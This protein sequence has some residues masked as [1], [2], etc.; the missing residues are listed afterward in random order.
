MAA[1]KWIAG[2]TA[3]T[4]LPEAA[5]LV[6]GARLQVVRDYLSLALRTPEKDTEYIHQL[7]V[8]A[9]RANAAVRIF[10]KCLPK[11]VYKFL[12]RRLRDV[13]R[14]A[15]AARDWDVFLAGLSQRLQDAPHHHRGLDYLV[16][17]ALAQRLLAQDTLNQAVAGD[18]AALDDAMAA[19]L[20][21]VRKPRHNGKIL[22]DQARSA[23]LHLLDTLAEAAAGD[24]SD[25]VQLHQVRIQAKRLRYGMEIFASC[26]AEEFQTV[27]Y[28][29]VE[30]MQDILGLAND[31]HTAWQRLADLRHHLQTMLPQLW[32]HYAADIDELILFHQQ[33]QAEHRL[34]FEEWWHSWQE[35][36]G[37]DALRALL[38]NA[39][40]AA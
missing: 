32:E 31:S 22:L 2:L 9:R 26:F 18:A 24:L 28:A 7:R 1:G 10:Q 27:H 16:G 13:R 33:R 11:K 8:G 40:T 4:P 14:G 39:R 25:Y 3:T 15:G 38:E 20:A 12:Q 21:A 35:A 37:Q 23:L 29:A 17:H 30:E 6:L 19:V 36:G 34:H 5:H